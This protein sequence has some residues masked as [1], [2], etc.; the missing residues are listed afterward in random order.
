MKYPDSQCEIIVPS[1]MGFSEEQ[2]T[3]TPYVYIMKIKVKQ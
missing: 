1:K 3:V 2:S